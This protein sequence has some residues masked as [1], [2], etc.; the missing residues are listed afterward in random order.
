MSTRS[1]VI[2]KALKEKE[3]LDVSASEIDVDLNRQT[4]GYLMTRIQNAAGITKDVLGTGDQPFDIT[5]T[6]VEDSAGTQI[7]PSVKGNQLRQLENVGTP[8]R[9]YA[10][11][12]SAG[13]IY[14]VPAGTTFYLISLSARCLGTSPSQ[15]R[16][17]DDT[18]AVLYVLGAGPGTA[19]E[20]NATVFVPPYI[21][22]AGYDIHVANVA[23][24]IDA[25]AWG[26]EV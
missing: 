13:A 7:D 17:R 26:Y 19:G 4:L 3:P 15:I 14:T 22:P 18:G 11:T 9:I 21:C 16:V 12:T 23:G 24:G 5:P 6:G 10:S 20:A 8:T 25:S 1:S 2:K